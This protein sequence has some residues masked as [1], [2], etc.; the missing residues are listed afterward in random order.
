MPYRQ[1]LSKD[2]VGQNTGRHCYK[3]GKTNLPYG[4][5]VHTECLNT[6]EPLEYGHCYC[7][8]DKTNSRYNIFCP[9]H[10]PPK[11]LNPVPNDE[12]KL[13]VYVAVCCRCEARVTSGVDRDDTGTEWCEEY[14]LWFGCSVVS[15]VLNSVDKPDLI[16][17]LK[18]IKRASALNGQGCN[19]YKDK[20]NSLRR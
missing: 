14:W 2:P 18:L 8:G 16:H 4:C 13:L 17:I 10:S 9:K 20:G 15:I 5:L 6:T 7:C 19:P 11:H 1:I 12:L 3:C